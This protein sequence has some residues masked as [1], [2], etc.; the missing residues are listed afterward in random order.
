MTAHVIKI[1]VPE[2]GGSGL[3]LEWLEKRLKNP[4]P[5]LKIIGEAD[6]KVIQARFASKTAPDGSAWAPN[7][8]LTL[9]L[10]RG[11]A[12]M[13]R[14][15]PGLLGSINYLVS[16]SVLTIGPSKTYAAIQQF[17]GTVTAKGGALRIPVPAG[18]MINGRRTNAAGGIFLKSIT[19]PPR[20]YIGIG[21]KDIE[22]IGDAVEEY[23]TL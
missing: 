23:F 20:P 8:P 2:K 6:L 4:A 14:S 7:R 21:A 15:N 22:A 17:G 11:G 16:G 3:A 10:A 19:I 12:M 5:L 9:L 13:R 18:T 1:T